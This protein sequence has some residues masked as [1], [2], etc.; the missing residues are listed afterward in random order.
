MCVYI[1]ACAISHAWDVLVLSCVCVENLPRSSGLSKLRLVWFWRKLSG[2]V[3]FQPGGMT[4]S[5]AGVD[6]RRHR[7]A[8]EMISRIRVV[9]TV[10][11]CF[12]HILKSRN[13]DQWRLTVCDCSTRQLQ[14][15]APEPEFSTYI[16]AWTLQHMEV[17]QSGR[18]IYDV[19]LC[20]V[21]FFKVIVLVLS[22]ASFWVHLIALVLLLSVTSSVSSLNGNTDV[23]FSNTKQLCETVRTSWFQTLRGAPVIS[24]LRKTSLFWPCSFKCLK[25]SYRS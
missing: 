15:S 13:G 17:V 6:I 23:C 1:D 8:M 3:E 9:R 7:V 20:G 16:E 18:R 22:H 14:S 11:S 10:L 2:Q 25:M 4:H 5:V 24:D 19:I 12:L 21:A